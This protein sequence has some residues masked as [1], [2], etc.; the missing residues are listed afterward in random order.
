MSG[1]ALFF[2]LVVWVIIIGG[3]GYS[4]SQVLKYQSK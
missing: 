1:G 2:M 3:A 4:L